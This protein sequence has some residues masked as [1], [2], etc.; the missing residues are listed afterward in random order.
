[1]TCYHPLQAWLEPGKQ[2]RFKKPTRDRPLFDEIKLPCR[3]CIGCRIERQAEWCVR[4]MHE[5][6]L[7][8]TSLFVTLTYDK[9]NVPRDYGLHHRDW[10]LFMKKL[11]FHFKP[12]KIRFFMCG[13]Y[14]SKGSRPHFHAILFGLDLDDMV[15]W[16]TRTRKPAVYD[17]GILVKPAQKYSYYTSETVSKIW[18]KGQVL[19]GYAG[20]ETMNYVSGY[21]LKEQ[22]LNP[23]TKQI[24]KHEGTADEK[25]VTVPDYSIT[26]PETGEVF[27]RI[28]P[29]IRMSTNPGIG[30]DWFDKYHS[31]VFP[32]DFVINDGRK[33][34]A[35]DYYMRK[36]EKINPDLAHQIKTNRRE[37]IEKPEFKEENTPKR[38]ATRKRALIGKRAFFDRGEE[39]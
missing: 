20:R 14:G 39:L 5:A 8:L 37:E 12:L 11:R 22:V 10:Q 3:Q 15:V 16:K 17:N 30:S 31:D 34:K 19:I 24:I 32:S 2:P 27:E 38:L 4:L 33:Q 9:E 25:V 26:D 1:M 18:G 28:A 7:Y 35:P 13:E 29:Y 21:M 36:L 6:D 23:K